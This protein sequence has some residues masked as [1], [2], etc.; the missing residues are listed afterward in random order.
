M[1]DPQ[2]RVKAITE[3]REKVH[4]RG[5]H[6]ALYVNSLSAVDVRAFLKLLPS[7]ENPSVNSVK[8]RISNFKLHM[9]RAKTIM[10]RRCVGQALMLKLG[11]ELVLVQKKA[12]AGVQEDKSHAGTV[13]LCALN[14]T[15]YLPKTAASDVTC[16]MFFFTY[17]DGYPRI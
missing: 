6:S 4:M 15:V 13:L 3:F 16:K 12:A 5:I 1:K 10:W 11:N 2:L 17:R 14:A 7:F 9:H 8:R